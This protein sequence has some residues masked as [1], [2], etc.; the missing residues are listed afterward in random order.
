MQPSPE[1]VASYSGDEMSQDQK[2]A[3]Q[4]LR[5]RLK[6]VSGRRKA[7]LSPAADSAV[8]ALLEKATAKNW[9]SLDRLVA[10]AA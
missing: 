1:L 3:Y 4:E 5:G 9:P 7:R 8:M 2:K 10:V 6:K